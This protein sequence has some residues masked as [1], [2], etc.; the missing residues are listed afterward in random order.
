MAFTVE[1]P[2]DAT[3]QSYIQG[4]LLRQRNGD[5]PSVNAPEDF[6]FKVVQL[7]ARL[8]LFDMRMK[9]IKIPCY[10]GIL[11]SETQIS[12]TGKVSTLS[13]VLTWEI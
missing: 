3:L 2:R 7:R 1:I 8:G 10:R 6:D 13:C 4:L 9:R 12:T 11:K 5:F